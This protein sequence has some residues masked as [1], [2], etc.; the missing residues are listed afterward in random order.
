MKR[1]TDGKLFVRK[2]GTK[3]KKA[4]VI[5]LV[6]AIVLSLI[7][8]CQQLKYQRLVKTAKGVNLLTVDFQQSQTLRYKFVSSRETEVIMESTS[9]SEQ[10]KATKYAERMEMVVAY[11]PVYVDPYSYTTIEARCESINITRDPTAGAKT[12][13]AR[14]FAG[15]SYSIRVGPTG[16]IR[17]HRELESLIREVAQKAFRTSAQDDRIKDPDMVCDFLASQWFLWDAVSSIDDPVEGVAVGDT[18]KS[19]LSIPAPMLMHRARDVVYKLEEVRQSDEGQIAVITGS[20]SFAERPPSGW[21]IPYSGRFR[22]SGPFGLYARYRILG[23]QGSGRELFNIEQGRLNQSEQDYE[24]NMTASL[25]ML[26]VNIKINIKQ[27]LSM[28]LLEN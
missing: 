2:K 10:S 23:L 14:N 4:V 8:A 22:M 11:T 20:Y 12:D 7:S 3:L 24:M 26:P 5:F 13:A 18:W 6:T 25:M 19:Q 1:L 21:P 16:K 15:K 9:G 27:K 28:Q 17:D